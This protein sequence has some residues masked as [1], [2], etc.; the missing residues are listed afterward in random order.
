MMKIKLVSIHVDDQEKAAAFYG[1]VLGFAKRHDLDVGGGFRW[2]TFV[3]PDGHDDVELV[4]EPNANPVAKAY[5]AGLLEQGIPATAFE[6][7]DVDAEHRRLVEHGVT[8]TTEPH[9]QGPVKLAVFAD[10][11]GNLI[12]IYQPPS[13]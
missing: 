1:D 8:F 5:Q 9:Q 13:A 11:C 12:Q 10:T 6:V 7:A 2:L 3:S 4:L